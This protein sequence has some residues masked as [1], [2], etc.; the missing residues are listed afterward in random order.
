HDMF[1]KFI[2]Q[3]WLVSCGDI[4]PPFSKFVDNLDKKLLDTTG[5][6]SLISLK[7]EVALEEEVRLTKSAL[8]ALD[9]EQNRNISIV[10]FGP[11]DGF[12]ALITGVLKTVES[13]LNLTTHERAKLIEQT[14][15]AFQN[16]V[17]KVFG[18]L[19]LGESSSN[20][21]LLMVGAGITPLA[22]HI[23]E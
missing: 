7:R 10:S 18:E 14:R 5:K 8:F 15:S 16:L 3:L 6:D 11:K 22:W 17:A 13:P 4:S 23:G 1:S 12:D 19:T 21:V 20:R 2:S 9:K